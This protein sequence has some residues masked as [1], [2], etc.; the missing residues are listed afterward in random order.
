MSTLDLTFN[1]A[2]DVV[3]TPPTKMT[4]NMQEAGDFQVF[5]YKAMNLSRRHE[6]FYITTVPTML[7]RLAH[8]RDRDRFRETWNR[9]TPGLSYSMPLD[10]PIYLRLNPKLNTHFLFRSYDQ[11]IYQLQ[12]LFQLTHYE[13]YPDER[14]E[15]CTTY[16]QQLGLHN[17]PV[18]NVCEMNISPKAIFQGV[19]RCWQNLLEE[20]NLQVV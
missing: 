17:Q 16:M 14:L 8:V 18:I 1:T 11:V 7:H 3:E 5:R 12:G 4:M 10:M 13:P 19:I 15:E 20:R 9:V 2:I 6:A